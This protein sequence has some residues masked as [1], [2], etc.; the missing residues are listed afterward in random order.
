MNAWPCVSLLMLTLPGC[1]N[2]T[3][4]PDAPQ[5]PVIIKVPV[6]VPCIDKVPTAPVKCTPS[7]KDRPEMLRC[8][9]VDKVRGDAYI[10]E[11]SAIVA[12]CAN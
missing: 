7:S 2:L 12:V 11:L 1:S 4:Q 5:E 3:P 9:L 6:S 8:I 10:E